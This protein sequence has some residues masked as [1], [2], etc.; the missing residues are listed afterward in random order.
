LTKADL[1]KKA[2][3]GWV[4]QEMKIGAFI[5]QWPLAKFVGWMLKT[6]DHQI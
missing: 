2:C 3:V 6:D 5:P 4:A 1:Q